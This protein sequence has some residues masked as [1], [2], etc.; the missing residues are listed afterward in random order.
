M[1]IGIALLAFGILLMLSVLLNRVA[2]RFPKATHPACFTVS[3]FAT[4]C[5]G[6]SADILVQSYANV[7]PIQYA[8]LPFFNWAGLGVAFQGI[9]YQNTKSRWPLCIPN[10]IH[11][12]I[13]MAA[14]INHLLHL[15]VAGV[16][17]GITILLCLISPSS[18]KD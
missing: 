15:F 10:A 14:G 13:A 16:L 18:K 7:I 4:V 12:L 1:E 6:Y 3:I 2:A 11:A 9:A 8:I 17:A 5:F